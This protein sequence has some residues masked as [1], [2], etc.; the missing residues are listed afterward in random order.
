MRKVVCCL[1]IFILSGCS[2]ALRN[3]AIRLVVVSDVAAD[4]LADG[5]EDY[6][7][8][9]VSGCSKKLDPGTSTKE[10]AKACLGFASSDNG[11][12]LKAAMESL[13]SAQMAIRIAVECTDN[14]LDTPKELALNCV[15]GGT[16]WLGLTAQLT[17]AWKAIKPFYEAL[18]SDG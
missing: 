13:V 7:D 6:V 3:G 5:Y 15:G 12:I 4:V 17:E 18:R 11:Q 1:A 8:E 16:D 2:P 10:E 9:K 14:P